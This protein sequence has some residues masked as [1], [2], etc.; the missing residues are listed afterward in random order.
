MVDRVRVIVFAVVFG[1]AVALLALGFA[2]GRYSAVRGFDYVIEQHEQALTLG[3]LLEDEE[4]RPTVSAYHD[5]EETIGDLDEISWAVPNIPT[6]FVGSAPAPGRHH[7]AT[8]N[9]L[10]FRSDNDVEVPKPA[11]RFRIFLTGGSTVYGSGAPDQERTIAVYLERRLNE[12]LSPITGREYEVF[13]AANPGWA[14]TQERILIENR[15][16]ALEP[17]LLIAFSG[18]NDVH[19]GFYGRDVMWFRSQADELFFDLIRQVYTLRKL[20]EIPEIVRVVDG[21]IPAPRVARQLVKNVRLGAFALSS[22]GAD[23]VFMLQPTLAVTQKKLSKREE[24][25]V[26]TKR[27]DYFRACYDEIDRALETI[28]ADNFSY[29]DFS[30]VFDAMGEEDELFIDSYHF[31]DRGNEII[32]AEIFQKIRERA[33]R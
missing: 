22:E 8:I 13:S 9:A 19:W 24:S 25:I 20:P 5:G 2:A 12:A 18:N 15:L 4:R 16:S 30:S 7:N 3:S 32:A 23:Y 6:P 21:Q 10:Q 28:E 27:V 29:V 17:D 14:T 33:L 26:K 1:I 11:N 31:G